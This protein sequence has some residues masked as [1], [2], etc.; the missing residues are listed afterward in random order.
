M[1]GTRTRLVYLLAASHSGSTLLSL[2][3]GSHP[4]ICTV[5][6]L[7]QTS[8]GDLQRYR[9]SCGERIRQCPFWMAVGA[10]LATRGHDF[11]P[12]NGSTDLTFGASSWAKR[13]LR[14]LHRGPLLERARDV[15]LALDVRWRPHLRRWQDANAR[16]AEA[17]CRLS[18]RPVI[19][20]SSKVGIRLKYL[21]RNRSLEVKVLRIVRDGRAV[22][23][24]YVDPAHFA[25]ARDEQLRGGGF[26]GDRAE[27]RL[28]MAEAARE[29][30][31]SNEEAEALLRGL[32]PASFRT[33]RYEEI[34]ADPHVALRPVLDWAGVDPE[35]PPTL[36]RG[37]YHVVGN[38]MR[39]DS[40]REIRLDDRWRT[41]LRADDLA[42]FDAV[43]GDL[44]RRLGFS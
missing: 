42:T 44:N 19:V 31:R 11:L 33:V 30:R 13:L 39:L 26:G 21:L 22:A 36:A 40:T 3:L 6:E 34:C 32:S 18:R 43:A 2:L 20:D 38:G 41:A 9:C 17:V 16:L 24:T 12:G 8:L 5:G 4:E 25:D 1:T 23:L 27:E 14:P 28:S 15:A 29:W 7:K 10:D 35:V 37:T